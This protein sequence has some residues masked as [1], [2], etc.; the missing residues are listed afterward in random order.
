MNSIEESGVIDVYLRNVVL[1]TCTHWKVALIGLTAF[2]K[3]GV[4]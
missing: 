1:S 2:L 4:L 3:R